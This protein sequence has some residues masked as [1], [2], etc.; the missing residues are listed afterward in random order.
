MR[1]YECPMRYDGG[2]LSL[3]LGGGITGCGDWQAWMRE[4]L[5]DTDWVLLNPR[6]A[7]FDATDPNFDTVQ[8]PWEHDHLGRATALMFWF[9]PETLCPITLYEL[10]KYTPTCK[11]IILGIHPDY[12]RKRDVEMQTRLERPLIKIHYDLKDVAQA[13]RDLYKNMD[14]LAC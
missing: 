12:K 14:A 2:D 1:Y 10:G 3:F 4:T 13:A 8:I 6:R 7:E 5:S 11:P 9:P